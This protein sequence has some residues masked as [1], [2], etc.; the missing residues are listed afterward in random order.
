MVERETTR[1]EK[2]HRSCAARWILTHAA[3]RLD[4]RVGMTSAGARAGL[5]VFAMHEVREC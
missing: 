3:R 1:R 4:R 2:Y 5:D